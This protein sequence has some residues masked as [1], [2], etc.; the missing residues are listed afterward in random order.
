MKHPFLMAVLTFCVFSQYTF[1]QETLENPEKRV[2]TQILQN[3][4]YINL[5]SR[6]DKKNHVEN[7]LLSTNI[8][9]N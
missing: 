8:F 2:K 3:C 5:K 4:L 6:T 9:S 7:Q 1:S